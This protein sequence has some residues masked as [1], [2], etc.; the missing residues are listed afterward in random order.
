MVGALLDGSPCLPANGC[1]HNSSSCQ[2]EMH[3][4][5]RYHTHLEVYNYSSSLYRL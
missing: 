2:T 5:P 1:G 3:T 4:M